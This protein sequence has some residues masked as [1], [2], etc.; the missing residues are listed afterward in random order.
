MLKNWC[1]AKDQ[2]S[3]ISQHY[4]RQGDHLPS[5][6]INKIINSRDINSAVFNLRQIFF[7]L[8]AY[9]TRLDSTFLGREP[10]DQAF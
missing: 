7:G 2:L 3:Q 4:I 5:S 6:L 10:N 8:N 1:W 9:T